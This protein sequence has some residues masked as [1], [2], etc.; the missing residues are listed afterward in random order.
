MKHFDLL[1]APVNPALRKDELQSK[2]RSAGSSGFAFIK[3]F[4]EITIEDIPSVGGKTASLGEML[5]E[6]GSKRPWQF[7]RPKKRKIKSDTSRQNHS[8]NKA[9]HFG[10]LP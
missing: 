5:R 10:Q 9:K 1:L 4:R 8:E 7:Y 6:L 3:Q 2:I